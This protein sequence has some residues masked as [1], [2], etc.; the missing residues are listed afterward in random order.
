MHARL[1]KAALLIAAIWLLPAGR[2]QLN[3][4]ILQCKAADPHGPAAHIRVEISGPS[5]SVIMAL[6]SDVNGEFSAVLP[7]G[8]YTVRAAAIHAACRVRVRPLTT[9]S[10]DLRSG[11]N[12]TAD[13]HEPV[14]SGAHDAAQI[15]L[16]ESPAAVVYPM[17]F[18]NLANVRL[19]RISGQSSTWAA[20]SFRLNGLD[21]TDSYQ[22]GKPVVL[23][24]AAAE[25]AVVA[26]ESYATAAPADAY[27]VATFLRGAGT[28]W[29]SRLA[30]SATGSAFAGNNAPTGPD[31]GIVLWPEEFHWFTR[32]SVDV[33][34]PIT[35]WADISATATGQWASQTAPQWSS[36]A[37]IN[38]R[39]L[40]GNARGRVRLSA[41]DQ[42]D[43]LYSGSRLDLS[44]GGSPAGMEAFLASSLM[45]T[46]YGV[47]GFQNLRETDHFDFVQAGWTHEFAGAGV[48]EV[49]YGYSP[50]HLD[51][52]PVSGQNV[53]ARLDLLDLAPADSPL[54]NLAVR[55]R[56]QIDAAY[57]SGEVR[58]AR[59][60]HSFSFGGGWERAHPQNRF[61]APLATDVI[62][63]GGQPAFV[64]RLNTPTVSR[65]R[66]ESMAP[67]AG[68]TIRFGH[69][70]TAALS[71]LLDPSR[72]EIMG[73][74]TGGSAPISWVNVY[75]RAGI[76][77]LVPGFSRLTLHGNYARTYAPL[78]GRYLDFADPASLSALVYDAITGRLVERFGGAWSSIAP[79]LKRPYADT[80]D[81]A[82]NLALPRQSSISVNLFRRDEKDRLAA[83]NTGIPASA[84][85]PATILD[86]GPDFIPGTFDD[87]KLEVYA[88][89]P[90]TLGHDQ[91]L[92][93]NPAGLREL[94][95]AITAIASTHHQLLDI[96]ASFT[97]EKSFGPTNPGS[98]VWIND[99]GIVG[100]LYSNP[101]TLIDATGHP[102]MDHAFIGK[103][104]AVLATPKRFGGLEFV[105]IVNYFDGLPFARELLVTGLPQG[106]FLID[107]TL[108]GSPEGGNRAQYVL[109]WN[110]RI[111]REFQMRFGHLKL[112]ADM[113]N[114]LN[115]G[116]KI[117]ESDL[118]GL[119]FNKRPAL[120]IP[121]P[122][123]LS[124]ELAWR[125]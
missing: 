20:T 119:L 17:D 18:A 11:E 30:A 124:L 69:S 100:A 98:S 27:E 46:F 57:Q 118:S 51:T 58:L 107:T 6:I 120:A 125:F 110:L 25:E 81:I 114:V 68:D 62:S 33:S 79:G 96:R 83:I 116:N 59:L 40:F 38:S 41:R 42:L 93:T 24:D 74:H 103:F 91:Y 29:H 102:F 78:A 64:V 94:S 44:K 21:A 65:E 54:S 117:V 34:G 99:P 60:T 89:V 75:P 123:M 7:Y 15:L 45:P 35:R 70:V 108:R 72:G 88:Q 32:D 95:E 49:R 26:R 50:A 37:P 39:M 10:C 113:V 9:A 55:T 92:L 3:L 80:F 8:I 14:P 1:L 82:A 22:P 63:S 56:H 71:L 115:N 97:V 19:P 2:A 106:P 67:Y 23:D 43:A 122:R 66:I 16:F 53:P 47:E 48:L 77:L 121:P 84:Y 28:S 85:Y 109:N 86:P 105:N 87:Q 101:N 52:T 36:G 76:A 12:R 104:E 112:A 5:G 4:G 13:A 31:R 111:T 90:A 61:Q 73:L